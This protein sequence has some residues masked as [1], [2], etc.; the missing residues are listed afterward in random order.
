MSVNIDKKKRNK[1]YVI[2]L[3]LCFFIAI[4]ITSCGNQMGNGKEEKKEMNEISTSG[5]QNET[6]IK[7][8][9]IQKA[10]QNEFP[11]VIVSNAEARPNENVIIT[12]SL[13]NNPG[14]L[15]MSG[16]LSYDEEVLSLKGVENGDAF[17]DVL[18]L[19]SSKNLG[20]GCRFLWSGEE[21]LSNQISDGIVLKLDFLVKKNT[22][23]MKTAI[24]FIP[25]QEGAY[26]KD[27]LSIELLTENGYITI[28]SDS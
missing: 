14:L 8:E 25:D 16:T 23:E 9:R 22:N 19:N 12:I 21:I 1:H 5:I 27:L 4:C 7:D 6:E 15:G 24:S 13:V 18:E 11:V 17:K 20:S 28:T 10:K 3:F 26:D 2:Y